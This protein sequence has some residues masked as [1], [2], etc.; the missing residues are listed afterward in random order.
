[1]SLEQT[2]SVNALI[3]LFI[4]RGGNFKSTG[5]EQKMMCAHGA[6]QGT[7]ATAWHCRHW[8]PYL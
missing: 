7:T 1:M 3:V 4:K 5:P 8:S 2:T 6:G